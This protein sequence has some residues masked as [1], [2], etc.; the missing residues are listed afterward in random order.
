[1]PELNA[2]LLLIVLS[3]ALMGVGFSLRNRP[4]GIGLLAAGILL[5]LATLFRELYRALA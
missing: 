1:M 5:V 4:L 2:T 3:F